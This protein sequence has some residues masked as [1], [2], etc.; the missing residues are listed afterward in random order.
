MKR[1]CVIGLVALAALEAGLID[2][3]AKGG[4]Q[5]LWF[6]N[7]KPNGRFH[8][9][10]NQN[11]P[12]LSKAL[13]QIP[14]QGA[15]L[16]KDYNR[17]IDEFLKVPFKKPLATCSRLLAMKRPDVFFCVDSQNIENFCADF[18]IKAS[19]LNYETYWE[20]VVCKIKRCTWYNVPEP[21]NELEKLIH[22]FRGALLDCFY[23]TYHWG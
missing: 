17:F 23:Y 3:Q 19:Q 21:Q 10:V 9:A 8:Q 11:N 16:K 7:M 4:I 22:N 1:L 6:G 2:E 5:W 18:G 13:D 15:V 14:F 12:C 20:E